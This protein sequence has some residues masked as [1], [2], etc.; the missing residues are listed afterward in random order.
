VTVLD[1][2]AVLAYLRNELAARDV[3][4]VLVSGDCLVTATCVA[5][6]TDQMVRLHNVDARTAAS[7]LAQLP[8]RDAVP[9]DAAL[10]ASAGQ[11]RARHYHRTRRSVSMADCVS[12]A[13]AHQLDEPLATSDPALLDMCHDEGISTIVLPGSDGSVWTAP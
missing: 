5:E 6:V 3:G 10:G 7:Y 4:P 1:A 11:L 12:A 13:A 9:L 8:L 2:Y